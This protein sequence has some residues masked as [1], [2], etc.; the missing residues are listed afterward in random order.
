MAVMVVHFAQ[1][2]RSRRQVA[3]T[4]GHDQAA[5]RLYML[6]LLTLVWTL[7]LAQQPIGTLEKAVSQELLSVVPMIAVAWF[8]SDIKRL[9]PLLLLVSVTCIFTMLV[10][11]LENF[12]QRP[13]WF[14]YMPSFLQVDSSLLDTYLAPQSRTGDGRYRIRATFGIVIFYSQYLCLLFPLLFWHILQMR[15]TKLILAALLMVLML[16]IVWYLNSRTASLALLVTL[17]GTASLYAWRL[18]MFR[19]NG[20]SFKTIFAFVLVVAAAAAMVVAIAGSHRLQMYTIGGSQHV[21]SDAVRDTQWQKAWAQLAKNPIG[22]GA[23]NS[24]PLVGALSPQG[25]YI[26][27]SLY[28]NLL[29]D[30]GPLGF[31]GFLGCLLR[32][33]WL[34]ILTYLRAEDD[35]DEWAAP[36]SLGILSFVVSAYVISNISNNF[37]VLVL[38]ACV[39]VLHR[40]QAL[41]VTQAM[42]IGRAT[43]P[44][45]SA[46]V[47]VRR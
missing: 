12:L 4:L 18:I 22:V 29:V 27:D 24:P 8:L 44:G 6:Y 3:D 33:C 19:R 42:T 17:F 30:Y 11:V 25:I 9:P 26:V 20:D 32:V 2:A 14:G 15:G 46:I 34:G 40:R 23:G 38:C 37:I 1:N 47:A 21:G 35:L 16:I 31:I 28:I 41:R 13:P 10:A 45:S 36:L 39:L 7:P 43:G 5:L